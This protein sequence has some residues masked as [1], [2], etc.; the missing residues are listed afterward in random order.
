MKEALVVCGG[1]NLAVGVTIWDVETGDHLLHIP[2]CAS[3]FH[4]L[5]CLRHHYLV[6]SQIQTPGSVSG[7]VIFTWPFSKAPS[8]LIAPIIP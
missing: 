1:K 8:Y 5:T 6:A 3:P 7:G 4:G 2:T